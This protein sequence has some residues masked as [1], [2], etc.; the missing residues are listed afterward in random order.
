MDPVSIG[1]NAKIQ[2]FKRGGWEEVVFE[3]DVSNTV[4]K[5]GQQQSLKS[6]T[7]KEEHLKEHAT[8][9]V[10][11]LLPFNLIGDKAIIKGMSQRWRFRSK[12]GW[13]FTNLVKKNAV[14]H[15]EIRQTFKCSPH[16]LKSM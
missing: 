2:V 3:T 11:D 15:S 5:L 9:Y 10:T 6:G 16:T 1:L 14:L 8:N 13:R 12:D 7:I 4:S